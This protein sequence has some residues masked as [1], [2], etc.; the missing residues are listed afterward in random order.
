MSSGTPPRTFRS[1]RRHQTESQIRSRQPPSPKT[2]IFLQV[3]IWFSTRPSG[4]M[5]NLHVPAPSPLIS[6]YSSPNNSFPNTAS[7]ASPRA[8]PGGRRT[9]LGCAHGRRPR[10]RSPN[11]DTLQ[12]LEGTRVQCPKNVDTLNHWQS[13]QA[14][15]QNRLRV[16]QNDFRCRQKK[17]G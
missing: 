11:N 8:G 14:G 6:F 4:R 12:G 10:K 3:F 16:P 13:E 1:T 5:G 7:P 9:L 15:I 17:L 2:S